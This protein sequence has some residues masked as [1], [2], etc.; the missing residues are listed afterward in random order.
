MAAARK[1]KKRPEVR[2]RK[3]RDIELKQFA[4]V[5]ADDKSE[6]VLTL[7]TLA[8]KKSAN[9]HIFEVFEQGEKELD[10]RLLEGKDTEE[11]LLKK[12]KAKT[13][14]HIH[15]EAEGEIHMNEGSV[16]LNKCV[17]Y[18]YQSHL[19]VRRLMRLDV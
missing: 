13:D 8:L 14:K 3:W 1:G 19:T 9:I 16:A 4:T 17:Q 10:A 11:D 2:E 15:P 18:L 6:V 12:G 5:L 7:E